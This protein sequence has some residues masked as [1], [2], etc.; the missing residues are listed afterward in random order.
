MTG[1]RLRRARRR[2]VRTTAVSRRPTSERRGSGH[3]GS[4][5]SVQE[6]DVRYGDVPVVWGCSLDIAQGKVVWLFGGNGAGKTT[7]LRAVSRLVNATSG[8]IAFV[9]QDISKREAH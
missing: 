4:L 3:L 8:R 7:I 5:L 6:I 2:R 1:K 9:G